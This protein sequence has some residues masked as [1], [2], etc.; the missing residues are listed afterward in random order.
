[1][2]PRHALSLLALALPLPVVLSGATHPAPGARAL[3]EP[4]QVVPDP[5][6]S[7]AW[8]QRGPRPAPRRIASRSRRAAVPLQRAAAT[9][10]HTA[11]HVPTQATRHA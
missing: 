5:T 10:P 4:A 2:R 7:P 8:D 11:T 1:M 6:T 9:R 3:S